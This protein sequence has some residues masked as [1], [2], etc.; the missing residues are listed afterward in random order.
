M[1][2][3]IRHIPA[4]VTGTTGTVILAKCIYGLAKNLHF[5]DAGYLMALLTGWIIFWTFVH[6]KQ[7]R[8]NDYK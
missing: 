7:V 4:D 6:T 3:I 8:N 5:I 2:T 1:K